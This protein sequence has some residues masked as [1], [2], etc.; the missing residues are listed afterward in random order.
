MKKTIVWLNALLPVIYLMAIVLSILI[1]PEDETLFLIL[2][3][4]AF[5]G[6]LFPCLLPLLTSN[7]SRKF[8]ATANLWICISNLSLLMAQGIYW[9]IVLEETRK[10]TANG[11][12]GGGLGLVV[13][14]LLYLPHWASYFVTRIACAVNCARILR[15]K[16][17]YNHNYIL[18]ALM[19]LLPITDLISAMLVLRQVKKQEN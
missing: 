12:M 19:H 5:I 16:S 1:N 10:A 18:Y 3:V 6:L 17:Y 9:F 15:H 2:G 13:L 11:A 14:I 4:Y 8:L 7:A